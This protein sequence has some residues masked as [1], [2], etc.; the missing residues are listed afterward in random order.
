MIAPKQTRIMKGIDAPTNWVRNGKITMAAPHGPRCATDWER[1]S[2]RPSALMASCR[3]SSAIQVSVVLCLERPPLYDR[4][5]YQ[6]NDK[7]PNAYITLRNGTRN[8]I[9]ANL[10]KVVGQIEG[11]R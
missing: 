10:T 6:G 5:L 11:V 1:T 8:L 4:D 7:I 9:I 3:P 2:I